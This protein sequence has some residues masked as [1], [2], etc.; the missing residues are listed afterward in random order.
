MEVTQEQIASVLSKHDLRNTEKRRNI[1][2]LFLANNH[3]LSTKNIE[4]NL[5]KNIDRV[6]LYRLLNSFEE[7]GLIHKVVNQKNETFY[8]K[9]NSCHSNHR[10]EH[11]HFHCNNCNK[12]Y[13][14]DQIDTS[15]INIPKDF[16]YQSMTLDIYG[17]CKNC[18]NG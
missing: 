1:L 4:E 5:N 15:K 8:A 9:C 7:H 13:C 11:L 12:V 6:T 10:D 18:N 2:R 17:T 3:A 14:L 16:S